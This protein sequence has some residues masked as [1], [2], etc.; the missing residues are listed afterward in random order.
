MFIHS[1]VMPL[2][3]VCFFFVTSLSCYAVLCVLSRF[4]IILLERERERERE[5]VALLVLSS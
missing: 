1:S 5:L 2:L 4:A 3:F